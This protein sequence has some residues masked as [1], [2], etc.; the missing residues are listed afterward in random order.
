MRFIFYQGDHTTSNL[1]CYVPL[2][3]IFV[4]TWFNFT[5]NCF[6]NKTVYMKFAFRNPYA[7]INTDHTSG[8][9]NYNLYTDPTLYIDYI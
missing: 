3:F 7:L 6:T 8:T 5:S 4:E 9:R 2:Q 1:K